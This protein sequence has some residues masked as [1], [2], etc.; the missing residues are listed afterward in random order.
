[1]Q[2]AMNLDL[3][4]GELGIWIW[5][6]GELDF[7]ELG[8]IDVEDSG[9][10][11]SGSL[12]G[13]LLGFGCLGTWRFGFLGFGDLDFWELGIWICGLGI[14]MWGFRDLDVRKKQSNGRLSAER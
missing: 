3:D 6:V 8:I 14:W 4:V 1:M 11:V 2:I 9:I 12:E 13:R 5:G 10:W 7:G